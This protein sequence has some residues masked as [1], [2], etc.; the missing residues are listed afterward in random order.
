MNGWLRKWGYLMIEKEILGCILKDNSLINETII[1]TNQFSNEHYRLLFQSMQK[2]S[3]ENKAIDKVTL[4][5]DNYEY[6]SQLGG[7]SFITDIETVGN[8]ENFETYEREFIDKYLKKE[9]ESIAKNWLSKE[10][11]DTQTLI[12]DLQNLD[13]LSFSDEQNKNEILKSMFDLPY[14]DNASDIGVRSGLNSLDTYIGGFQ[15]QQSY[16]MGARPSMG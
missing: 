10:E 7:P 11:K 15:N 9:S 1:R 14:S 12:N 2:L 3:F 4:M 5:S 8:V 16:I 6:I 13:D